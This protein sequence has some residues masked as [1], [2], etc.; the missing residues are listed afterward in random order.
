M[1]NRG[2]RPVLQ[3]SLPQTLLDEIDES[4]KNGQGKNNGKTRHRHS[5][6]DARKQD[7]EDKKKRKAEFFSA[8]PKANP[9]KRVAPVEHAESPQRKKAKLSAPHPTPAPAPT[10][11]K[12][13][14]KKTAA[15]SAPKTTASAT[16]PTKTRTALEKLVSRKDVVSLPRPGRSQKEREDDAYITYLE[17]K[18]GRGKNAEDED[19]LDDLLDFTS[20]I[21][22]SMPVKSQIP[23]KTIRRAKGS[24]R[25]QMM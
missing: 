12:P 23:W 20:S 13:T 1:S 6:K 8:P 3:P 17:S 7:R 24:L 15:T 16:K 19:G 9:A 11:L 22:P 10:E 18:L 4:N 21:L 14:L 5:R 25:T 2:R